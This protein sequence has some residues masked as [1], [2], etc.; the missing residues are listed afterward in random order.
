VIDWGRKI[1]FD[2][3]GIGAALAHHRLKVPLN[4]GWLVLALRLASPRQA[5]V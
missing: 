4:H 3:K 2:H 5:V 1:D